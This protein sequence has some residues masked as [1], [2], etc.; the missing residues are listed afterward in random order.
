MDGTIT[1]SDVL[2][3]LRSRQEFIKARDI[4]LAQKTLYG[5]WRKINEVVDDI[6]PVILLPVKV[7]MQS[8]LLPNDLMTEILK[9]NGNSYNHE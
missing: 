9:A 2:E 1:R 6:D 4:V 8:C 5:D 3:E 7:S